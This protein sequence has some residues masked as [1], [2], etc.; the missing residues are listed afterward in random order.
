M[1]TPPKDEFTQFGIYETTAPQPL[2]TTAVETTLPLEL[3]KDDRIVFI[4]NTLFERAA[5]FPHFESLLQL[6]HPSHQL[7]IRTLAWSADEPGLMPRPANFGDIHQHLAVQKADVIF[8]AFGFNESF[9][10]P[11]KLADFRTRLTAFLRDLKTR[12]YNGTSAARIVLVSPIANENIRA[13]APIPAADLNNANL[14]LYTK[15]MAEVAALEK[16]GFAD[17]YAPMLA[18]FADPKSDFTF[19]GVHL[20]DRGYAAF[21]EALF[22]A[23]FRREPPRAAQSAASELRTAIADK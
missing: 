13:L 9:G 12:A 15:A 8:A 11:E 10:G 16:I 22:R 5:Q 4:G 19:N 3:R 7:V 17:V 18:A 1:P 2:K 23:T 6:A 14:A 20:E 21:A